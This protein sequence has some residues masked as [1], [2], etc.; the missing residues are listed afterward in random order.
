MSQK[1][2]RLTPDEIFELFIE[3]S[4]LVESLLYVSDESLLYKFNSPVFEPLSE[5]EQLIYR[6]LVNLKREGVLPANTSITLNLAK[7]ITSLLRH[8][9][10][11]KQTNSSQSP[12]IAFSD[13]V[14]F[15]IET[16]KK[17]LASPDHLTFIKYN[18]PSTLLSATKNPPLKFLDFLNT[19]FKGDTEVVAFIQQMMGYLLIPSTRAHA[20]FFLYGGGQNG[21]SVLLEIISALFP[22]HLIARHKLDQLTTNRFRVADLVGKLVNIT[23][24]EESKYLRSDIFKDLV[25]GEPVSAERKYQGS[26]SFTPY[27]TFLFSTNAIPTFDGL[28]KAA[29]RRLFIIP[30]T[31]TVPDNEKNPNLAQELINEEL[32]QIFAFALEGALSLIEHNYHLRR[33]E[34]LK[35]AQLDYEQKQ[36]AALDFF[37]EN[38]NLTGNLDDYIKRS[39]MYNLYK[40]WSE[41]VNRKPVSRQ[42]FFDEI[43]STYGSDTFKTNG[44]NP[45]YISHLQKSVRAVQGCKPTE[46]F[47]AFFHDRNTPDTLKREVV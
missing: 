22:P 36:S 26:F 35:Q 31:Y 15:N 39:D 5:P 38:Y 44:N 13:D 20:A 30:F 42:R 12:L 25:S 10:K 8:E 24:E 18:F 28:N 9:P 7:E 21:K 32:P 43:E 19:T 41:E 45:A 16:Q 23:G 46:D 11:V 2:K 27:C 6:E 1:P 14:V 33:P 40:D 17:T 37:N 4:S 29:R 3:A 47:T 34:S